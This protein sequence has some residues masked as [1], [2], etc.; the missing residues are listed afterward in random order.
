[1]K[2]AAISMFLLQGAIQICLAQESNLKEDYSAL[3]PEA[4]TVNR[5][6]AHLPP[7]TILTK[8]GMAKARTEMQG[9]VNAKAVQKSSE[10]IIQGPG[11][12]LKLKIFKPDTIHAVILDIHGGG[13]C[14]GTADNDALFNDEAASS[15]KVAVVSLD[16]RLAPENAFPACVDD[17]K[18]AIKWLLAHAKAEFGTDRII[19]QGASAGAHLAAVTTLYVRD[20]LKAIDKVR[21]VNLAYGVYDLGRT[22]SYRQATDTSFLSKKSMDE[23]FQMVFK[24]WTLERLQD[25]HF[26]P[27]Y[28]DLHG[29][30]SALFTIGALDPLADD[31][32]FMEA[33]WRMAGNKTFLAVYPESP[34]GVDILPTKMAL[35][36][37]NRMIEWIKGIAGM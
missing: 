28:A 29:L 21:G 14:N 16:Y 36:A 17:C 5:F 35:A 26:S 27:L 22:P 37:K 6:L 32:Y 19:I 20:S 15:C 23:I 18:A 12:N 10:K 24:G 30:P 7:S 11:G 33:R 4:R 34:H 8:E 9:F 31:T 3:L 1:M 13:W 25:P 2:Y